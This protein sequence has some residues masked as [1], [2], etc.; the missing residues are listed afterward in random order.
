[1]MIPTLLSAIG[2][3]YDI[4]SPCFE[5]PPGC[6][7]TIKYIKI[8]NDKEE[9]LEF[10]AD[11]QEISDAMERLNMIGQWPIYEARS[12]LDTFRSVDSKR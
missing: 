8:K 7:F 4:V 6:E 5:K 1:M 3:F 9:F 2:F 11:N 10:F 12:N